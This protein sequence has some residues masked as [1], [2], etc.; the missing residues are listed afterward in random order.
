[1]KELLTLISRLSIANT[2]YKKSLSCSSKNHAIFPGAKPVRRNFVPLELKY[3]SAH[4]RMVQLAHGFN[5]IKNLP[6]KFPRQALDIFRGGRGERVSEHAY[7][8][9]CLRSA[10]PST[11]FFDTENTRLIFATIFGLEYLTRSMTS[12]S[13]SLD[14]REDGATKPRKFLSSI[15]VIGDLFM[16]AIVSKRFCLST[17]TP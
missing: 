17:T 3:I 12:A 5:G 8:P 6:L 7:A 9:S 15:T 4:S 10:R 14:T 13:V 2:S 11:N 1:M 16:N